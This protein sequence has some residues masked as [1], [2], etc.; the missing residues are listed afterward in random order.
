[1]GW[2]ICSAIMAGLVRIKYLSREVY[3]LQVSQKNF[4]YALFPCILGMYQKILTGVL[5]H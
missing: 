3:A 5:P 2:W 4:I 1:M